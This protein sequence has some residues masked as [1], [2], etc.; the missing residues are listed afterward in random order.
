MRH[1]FVVFGLML[2][3]TSTLLPAT[4]FADAMST[5]AGDL[6]SDMR[7]L[8]EDHI[9]WTRNFIISFAAS[10]PDQDVVSARLLQNQVDIG[11]AIKPFYGEEAGN[12]L[13]GLLKEHILGAVEVLKAAKA[14]NKAQLDTANSKWQSNGDEIATFL[15][16]ANPKNWPLATLKA[17]MRKHLDLTLAEASNR[18]SGKF[19]EDVKDYDRVHEHILHFADTLTT[20]IQNQF[21]DKFK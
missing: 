2:I 11:N 10:L 13:G 17:E 14:G 4:T 7:K 20:G 12:K 8:W 16:T 15:S 18:L 6:R 5:A 19:A 21:P 1:T 3:L 9:T